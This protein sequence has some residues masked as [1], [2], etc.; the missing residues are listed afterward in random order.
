MPRQAHGRSLLASGPAKTRKRKPAR[1]RGLNALETAERDFPEVV[2]IRQHRL[3]EAED[4]SDDNNNRAD[5]GERSAKRRKVEDTGDDAGSEDGGSDPDGNPWHV[6]VDND[7]EDS[8][9]DSDEAFGESDEERFADF[10]FR[11]STQPK[12]A[13]TRAPSKRK[14]APRASFNLEEQDSQDSDNEEAANDSDDIEDDDDLGEDAVDLAAAWDLDDE[15]ERAELA[16]AERKKSSSKQKPPARLDGSEDSAESASG[17]SD[18]GHEQSEQSDLDMSDDEPDETTTSRLRSFVDG[19]TPAE[20]HSQPRKST[21]ISRALPDKP[22]PY[23]LASTAPISASDLLQHV[24]DPT[25]RQSLKILQAAEREIPSNPKDG[26]PGK[27]AAPLVKRQQDRLD[28]V[29]AYDHSKQALDKWVDTV[30]Q[31]RRAEHISF[32]LADPTKDSASAVKAFQPLSKSVVQSELESKIAEIM[33]ESGLDDSN[34]ND[35]ESDEQKY[36][37]LKEKSIPL[38]EVQARRRELRMQ[39]ELMF[40]E[41]IRAKRIKKIKSKAYRRVHR[42]E[43]DKFAVQERERLAAAGLLDSDEEREKNDR[44]RAE[45]RMGARHRESKWAKAA[46]ATGQTTW[47]EDAKIGVSELARRDDELRKRIEG[48]NIRGSD[49]SGSEGDS[50]SAYDSDS[51]DEDARWT[52]KLDG[53][54][55][56]SLP[57]GK[58]KLADMAFMRK[59]EAEQKAANDQELRS[60][61][62]GL[63]GANESESGSDADDAPTRQIFGKQSKKTSTLMPKRVQ[64]EEFEEALSEDEVPLDQTE[65]ATVPENSSI[66]VTTQSRKEASMGKTEKPKTKNVAPVKQALHAEH[67][68]LDDYTSPS[69]SEADEVDGLDDKDKLALDIFAGDDEVDLR[70]QFQKEKKQAVKDEGDRVIDNTLPG[71]GSWTGAG[72]SKKEQKKGKDRFQTTIKGIAPESRRDAKLDRVIVNEKRIKKNGKYLATELPHP[73]ESRQQYE[74]SLRLPVGPEWNTRNHFQDSIKPRVLVK[75]GQVIKPMAKPIAS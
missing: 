14:T 60:L 57:S 22:S 55:A 11:G 42:K 40:R 45:E 17:E 46:K 5:V 33:R 27:L 61:R 70:K 9:I 49:D 8:D 59:A 37:A 67:S 31:N 51:A 30:K 34:R 28:R 41:E 74:R 73:F 47:N 2:K 13:T 25:Q 15:D 66:A 65:D 12:D 4:D 62:R 29:A 72:V 21:T 19:L 53:L 20:R 39:R 75:Q 16:R 10:T 23:A 3:G 68:T 1:G 44:R 69:E 64:R 32:P 63:R 7:D 36:E 6:G 48:R 54:N 43:R 35:L 52:Q 38:E 24:K 58:S 71:W 18:S 50:E 56:E 26:I